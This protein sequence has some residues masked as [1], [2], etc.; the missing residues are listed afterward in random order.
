MRDPY[1]ISASY[2][3][4]PPSLWH[5]A[6]FK[7]WIIAIVMATITLGLLAFEALR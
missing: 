5:A 2:P 7:R 1:K 6:Y 3:N 4:D